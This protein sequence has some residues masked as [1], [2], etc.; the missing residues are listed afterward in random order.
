MSCSE[1]EIPLGERFDRCRRR[2]GLMSDSELWSQ[3]HTFPVEPQSVFLARRFVGGHLVE[4]GLGN[5][6][7]D[8]EL[9][10]SELATNALLHARTPFT[11]NLAQDA[12]AVVLTVRDGSPSAPVMRDTEVM[13]THGRGLLLVDM[14]SHNWGVTEEADGAASV[15]ASFLWR[16]D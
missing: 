16:K 8:V 2:R 4:H 11:L 1:A 6:V 15:W 14:I 7:A 13:D 5:L 9:V 3:T 12:R 10:T